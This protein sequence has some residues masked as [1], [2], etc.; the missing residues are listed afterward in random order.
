[1]TFETNGQVYTAPTPIFNCVVIPP[2]CTIREN[3]DFLG[4][5]L[6]TTVTIMG[7]STGQR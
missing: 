2:L 4:S 7:K 1:M 3:S 5:G 6:C